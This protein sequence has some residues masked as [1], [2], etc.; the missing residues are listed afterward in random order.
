MDKPS[1]ILRSPWLQWL[2]VQAFP[3]LRAWPVADWPAV[4][5]S[6][7]Q[8][9][10]DLLERLG[11]LAALAGSVWLLRP[12]AAPDASPGALFVAQ[13]LLA[14]PLLLLSAGPFFVRRIR[15]VL[16]A[17]AAARQAAPETPPQQR[18]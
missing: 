4:L 8:A 7:R 11:I 17:A 5:A 13:L 3:R 14:L 10:F 6:A 18:D 1:P 12:E 9:E 15:R 2:L 16:D